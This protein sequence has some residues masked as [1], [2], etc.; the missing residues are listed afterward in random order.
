MGIDGIDNMKDHE[1]QAVDTPIPDGEFV[2]MA[3]WEAMRDEA[4]ANE[5]EEADN[6]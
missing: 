2:D 6:G 1:E 5:P 3:T 4:L